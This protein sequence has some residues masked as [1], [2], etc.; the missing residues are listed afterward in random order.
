MKG[1]KIIESVW[2]NDA[3]AWTLGANTLSLANQT[4]SSVVSS[5]GLDDFFLNKNYDLKDEDYDE[6]F[7]RLWEQD[8]FIDQ[9]CIEVGLVRWT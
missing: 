1:G 3:H 9:Q 5:H 4:P 8:E 2:Q 6:L 7:K